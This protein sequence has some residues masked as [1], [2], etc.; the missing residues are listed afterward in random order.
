MRSIPC[1]RIVVFACLLAGTITVAAES[2]AQA[3]DGDRS[4]EH[5]LERLRV[6][7]REREQARAAAQ[8]EEEAARERHERELERERERAAIAA[9]ETAASFE[10]RRAAMRDWHGSFAATLAPLLATREE[11]YR[12]LSRRMFAAVRPACASFG[13][14]VEEAVPRYRAAPERVVDA[15]ARDLLA[16]YRESARHCVAGAYFSFTVRERQVQRIVSDLIA[17]LAPY[18][19][20]FPSGAP[21]AR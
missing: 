14:A 1:R 12:R 8:A 16:V 19:L 17:A 6:E 13:A 7:E 4:S 20:E 10:H 2:S 21:D 15:L 11:L 5:V 18:D 9:R 3:D